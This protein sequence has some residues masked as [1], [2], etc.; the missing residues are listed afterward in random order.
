LERKTTSRLAGLSAIAEF[1]ATRV[2][3]RVSAVFSAET[4]LDVCHTPVLCLNDKT[5]LKTFWTFW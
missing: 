5:Y 2:K 4:C 1:L 3:Q